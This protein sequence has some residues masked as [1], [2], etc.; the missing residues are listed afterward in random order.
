MPKIIAFERIDDNELFTLNEDK[1]T[2]SLK[3]MKEDFPNNLHMEY[4]KEQLQT[5]AFRPIYEKEK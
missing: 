4:T 2:Y 3:F 1:I 5:K